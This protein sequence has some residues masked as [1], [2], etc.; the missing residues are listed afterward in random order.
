MAGVLALTHKSMLTVRNGRTP[1]AR[2]VS[3]ERPE[4][5][6]S[7]L[8]APETVGQKTEYSRRPEGCLSDFCLNVGFSLVPAARGVRLVGS[9]RP[10]SASQFS[11]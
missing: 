3:S 11:P 8:R 6:R 1:A 10:T 2:V 5:V 9:C 4:W 7:G